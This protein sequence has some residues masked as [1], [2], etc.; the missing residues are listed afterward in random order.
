MAEIIEIWQ[1][2]QVQ[3]DRR[4]V[5]RRHREQRSLEAALAIMRESLAVAADE[6]CDAPAGAQPELLDRIEQLTALIRYGLRMAGEVGG[7][8]ETRGPGDAN[9]AAR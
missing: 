4:R 5:A 1:I 7:T 2:R 8:E 9:D 3:E 6:L